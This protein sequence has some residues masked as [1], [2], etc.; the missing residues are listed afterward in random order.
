MPLWG[1]IS[2]SKQTS[3]RKDKKGLELY[4]KNV[5]VKVTVSDLYSGI[6]EIEYSVESPY[7]TA[8]NQKGVVTIDNNGEKKA[9]SAAGWERT[10][11]DA[12]M[13]T[14]M[15]ATLKV[16]NNSNGI[17]V[18]IKLTDRSGNVSQESISFSIDKTNPQIKVTYDNNASDSKYKHYYK[19]KR[20]ATVVVT[21]RN[22]NAKDF[23]SVIKNKDGSAPA[24]DLTKAK[25]WK[26]RVNTKDPDKTT[27]TA[28]VVF[29]F[30][31][32]FTWD[33]SFVDM[34]NNSAAKVKQQKFT[35]DLTAPTIMVTYDNMK[36]KNGNYYKKNR[37]AS[38][39]IDEHNFDES[40]VKITGTAKENGRTVSFPKIRGWST[41]GDTHTA[42]I[43][44]ST[45]ALYTFSVAF[46]DKAGNKADKYAKDTFTVDKQNP[47]VKISNVKNKGAYNRKVEPVID[48]SDVNFDANSIEIILNGAN[49]EAVTL[50]GAGVSGQDGL[51]GTWSDI[52][53]G[54]RFTFTNFEK[55]K[56][57]DDI[58]M[59]EA[60]ITDKA[61]NVSSAKK[62]FSVNRFGSVYAFDSLLL[63]AMEKKYVNSE[64]DVVITETNV[65]NV[66]KNRVKLT[67]NGTPMDLE[68]KKDYEI[69]QTGG[70]GEWAQCI[71]TIH[72]DLF[73]GDGS[74]IIDLYSEDQAGNV[75]ENGDESKEASIT[76]GI[77]K[78]APIITPID[79]ANDTQYALERKEVEIDLKDNLILKAVKMYLN[80]AEIPFETDENGRYHIAISSAGHKQNLS[81]RA[82]DIAGNEMVV[83]VTGF[84]VSTNIFVRWV[85]N[86]PLFVGSLVGFGILV[87]FIVGLIIYRHQK[88]KKE[89]EKGAA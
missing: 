30:D 44:F 57:A 55:K 42:T 76:F 66:G 68:W 72:K 81:I 38:I 88:E 14:Q 71:Y 83:D 77:D 80:D 51:R 61:G 40:R 27:H 46:I 48:F 59:L 13:V 49:H 82:T 54:K 4:N 39:T 43:T 33:M 11:R 12:N 9:G 37:T 64:F 67:K 70:D 45:N 26:E 63:Q 78:T 41:D 28:K 16:K 73:A 47:L 36:S 58:Y 24:I 87:I 50:K 69:V 19:K 65:N 8:N 29:D 17:V 60:K 75:N 15:K 52:T 84:L 10:K 22:F 1:N 23:I 25:N 7:D 3:K 34:A 5:D 2:F 32:K 53:N 62:M 86:L 18:K 79:L 85:N 20:T 74:Y 89:V 35:I 21:E 56:Q 6:R 31:G